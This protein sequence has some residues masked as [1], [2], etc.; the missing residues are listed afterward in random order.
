M[1]QEVQL[2]G[3]RDQVLHLVR[4]DGGG[5]AGGDGVLTPT[6]VKLFT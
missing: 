5:G 4:R 1:L 6:L 2:P 3:D